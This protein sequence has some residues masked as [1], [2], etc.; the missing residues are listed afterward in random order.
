[1]TEPVLMAEEEGTQEEK[2]ESTPEGEAPDQFTLDQARALALQ[3]ARDTPE[4]YGQRYAR[5]DFVWE[6]VSQEERRYYYDIRLSFQPTGRW[7]SKP[8][9]ERFVVEKRG[10]IEVRLVLVEPPGLNRPAW[11]RHPVLLLAGLGVVVITAAA[12]AGLYSN[13]G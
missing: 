5:H 7:R 11:R 8:G 10:A 6:V 12:L 1:M 13:L 3:Y 4:F 9:L 2:L